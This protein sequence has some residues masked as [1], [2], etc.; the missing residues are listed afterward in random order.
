M[1][2]AFGTVARRVWLSRWRNSTTF[3]C[4]T[5]P[6]A[7]RARVDLLPPPVGT[8]AQLLGINTILAGRERGYLAYAR[9]LATGA[10]LKLVVCGLRHDASAERV[11][12]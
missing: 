12:S 1:R 10:A 4:A 2:A 5:N 9:L 8:G 6:S 7:R 3:P 11:V